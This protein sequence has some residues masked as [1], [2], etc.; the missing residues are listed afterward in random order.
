MFFDDYNPAITSILCDTGPMVSLYV[1]KKRSFLFDKH[2]NTSKQQ[3]NAQH[4]EQEM[5]NSPLSQ[6]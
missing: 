6:L 4:F 3:N 2:K 5:A 1:Y